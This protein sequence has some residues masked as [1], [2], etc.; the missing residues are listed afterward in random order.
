VK[1]VISGNSRIVVAPG[2]VH[3]R[4]IDD[5]VVILNTES[6]VYYGLTA[7]GTRVWELLQ[8]PC[9]ANQVKDAL[10]SEYDVEPERCEEDVLA[11]LQQMADA[12]LIE[13]VN[14]SAP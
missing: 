3:H 10:I 14:E 7:G 9:D 11:L 2:Q 5:E 8:K 1:A 13:L 6:G 4:A 12:G